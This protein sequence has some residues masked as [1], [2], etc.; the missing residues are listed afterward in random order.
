MTRAFGASDAQGAWVW[1]DAYEASEAAA[2]LFLQRYARAMRNRA[3]AG[4]RRPPQDARDAGGDRRARALAHETLRAADPPPAVLDAAPARLCGAQGRRHPPRRYRA[5]T[6]RRHRH[7]GRDGAMRAREPRRRPS[8]SQRDCGRARRAARR[9]LSR[10][11][12]HPPQRRI[13]RRLPC[14]TSGL[15]SCS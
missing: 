8:P 6:L 10:G 7:A 15:P 4:R 12:R 9:A 13:H 5:R 14:P 2:V 3:G 11:R 1:K